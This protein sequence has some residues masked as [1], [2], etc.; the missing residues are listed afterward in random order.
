MGIPIPIK[1]NSLD[2]IS[3]SLNSIANAYMSRAQGI[4]GRFISIVGLNC[5]TAALPL[6]K[7]FFHDELIA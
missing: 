1:L 7:G 2:V 4:V 3:N 5:K 6:Y